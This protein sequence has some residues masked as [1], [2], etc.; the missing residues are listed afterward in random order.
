MSWR[1]ASI[2]LEGSHHVVDGRPM[3]QSRFLQVQKFHDPGLAPVVSAE[4]AFHIREDGEA[5][6]PARFAQAWG[7]YQ[8]RAAVEDLQGWCHIDPLGEPIT[9]DRFAW[10]GNFQEGRCVARAFDG[11]YLHVQESGRPAYLEKYLYAGDYKDG[12]AV[13]RCP[14]SGLCTH[15]DL[16]G[17]ILHGQWFI[18]LDVFHKGLARAKDRSGWFHVDRAGRAASAQRYAEVEPFYNGLARV[19]THAGEYQ[20]VD[21]HGRSHGIVGRAQNDSFHELSAALVGHWRTDAIAAA[22]KLGVFDR[23]PADVATLSSAIGAPVHSV[24]R[25]LGGLWELGLIERTS[26]QDWVATAKGRLLD[27]R[28]ELQLADAALEHGGALRHQWTSLVDAIKTRDWRPQSVF[29][30]INQDP[31]RLARTQR[32]LSAYA[33]RDYHQ[34]VHALPFEKAARI[35]DVAGGC[36]TLAGLISTKFKTAEVV[37]LE[38]GEVCA[39]GRARSLPDGVRFISGNI[40]EQWSMRA[41]AFVMSRVL[42][43]WDDKDALRIL[44]N[45]RGALEAGSLG[46][47]LELLLDESTAF[48]RLCDLHLMVV[49]GG[50]ERTAREYA[51]LLQEA[52]FRLLRVEAGDSVV[53]MLVVEAT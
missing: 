46:A 39:M 40:F 26:S 34:F 7:F 12:A 48:G 9:R 30:L 33:T 50:R 8:N 11:G 18:D 20:V 28:H 32:M 43:D 15:I 35:I 37:V 17:R 6:Y 16:D 22:V 27:A 51:S 47:I 13:V 31:D 3:Y 44:R 19:L 2:A 45:A 10:C 14:A 1:R 36:G 21:Q 42:H 41:D 52:G 25:L 53:S 49:T 5:A 38:R 29:D 4:G 23:L 24:S